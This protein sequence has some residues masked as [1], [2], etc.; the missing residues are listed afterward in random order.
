MLLGTDT[1]KTRGAH[2]ASCS[3]PACLGLQCLERPRYFSG[4]LLTE[5]DLNS[6]QA[7]MLAKQ[8]L[9]NR[10]LHGSGIVCGL[11]VSC[12]KCAGAVTIQSGYAIDPCGNDIIVC[13]AQDFNVIQRI[14][15]CEKERKRQ[16]KSNCD[17]I[18]PPQDKNCKDLER[19]YCLTIAYN[20]QEARLSPTLLQGSTTSTSNGKGCGCNGSGKK[21]GCG[22]NS[23]S[24]SQ[25]ANS[26]A[27]TMSSTSMSP[28]S[29]SS[30][31][32]SATSCQP[33]RILEGYQLDISEVPPDYCGDAKTALED[34]LLAKVIDCVTTVR[35]FLDKKL[36]R[37]AYTLLTPLAF[38]GNV[39]EN[40]SPD[41]LYRSCC[42]LRQAI[43]DLY[44]QDPLNTHCQT[45]DVLSQVCCQSPP[46]GE[47][48]EEVRVSYIE[49]ARTTLYHLLALLAQYLL[50]CICQALLPPCSPAQADDRL[51]LACMTVKD[52]KII[53]ICNFCHRRYAGSFPS[54]Y[55]WLSLVPVIP[56]IAYAVERICCYD[57]LTVSLTNRQ[58]DQQD[59]VFRGNLMNGLL[60]LL[61]SIDP[62][63]SLRKEIFADNFAIPRSYAAKFEQLISKISSPL[64]IAD[65]LHSEAFNLT[66]IID[67]SVAEAT[68]ALQEEL[69]ALKREV[70]QLK[71]GGTPAGG[72]PPA[73]PP[74]A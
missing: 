28:S 40:V 70:D 67:K 25:Y 21:N 47:A 39:A 72:A 33:T 27:Q 4:Q 18:A 42:Y 10:Y 59:S 30:Q 24:S 3:C 32:S 43:H 54:L 68:A 56:L 14:H 55:Y 17:P 38:T 7:Y 23:S 52:D 15:D 36:P 74:Q 44:A 6:E 65:L 12:S 2:G 8:R 29:A 62:G 57:W 13:N 45:L 48:T 58:S 5:A 26:M 16:R 51:I 1:G 60:S 71:A 64:K 20:E 46:S 34:T 66:K 53:D 49:Q 19:H 35:G 73:E 61:N 41:D 22:C 11:Q 31:S 69:A 63:E 37:S 50:D 9:H